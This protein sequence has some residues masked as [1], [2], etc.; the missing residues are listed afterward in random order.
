MPGLRKHVRC[1][2]QHLPALI[3]CLWAAGAAGQTVYRCGNSYSQTACPGAVI[4]SADDSRSPAQKA[5]TDA[6]TRQA[7]QM[8]TQMEQQRV[9][10]E[11]AA[12]AAPTQGHAKAGPPSQPTTKT[13][14]GARKK[15]KKEPEFFTAAAAKDPAAAARKRTGKAADT[16]TE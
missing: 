15:P 4:V 10:S 6:A 14:G 3:G 2:W 12:R 16:G 13:A 5:Q 1:V 8:A 9:A 11:N 7:R